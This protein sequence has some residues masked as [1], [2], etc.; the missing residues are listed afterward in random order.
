[1]NAHQNPEAKSI[2]VLRCVG[3]A[4]RLSNPEIWR[5]DKAKTCVKEAKSSED[6][7]RISIAQDQ[8][9]VG[10]H[11]LWES[12]QLHAHFE[13]FNQLTMPIPATPKKLPM[14]AFVTPTPLHPISDNES[15]VNVV[16]K[17]PTAN[18][19]GLPICDLMVMGTG[20]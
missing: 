5:D 7:I 20:M 1:M 10:R 15:V 8:L 17:A 11:E 13:N 2:I 18:A 3:P 14:K 16:A 9:P 4:I 19:V 12:I 6:S